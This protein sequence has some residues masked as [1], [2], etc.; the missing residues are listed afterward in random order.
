MEI[1]CR[2]LSAWG[3]GP[4]SDYK[5][6][7][8]I[9]IGVVFCP[10]DTNVV[11]AVF[12]KSSRRTEPLLPLLCLWP[13][14]AFAG[15]DDTWRWQPLESISIHSFFPGDYSLSRTKTIWWNELSSEGLHRDLF[16]QFIKR[17]PHHRGRH[18]LFRITLAETGSE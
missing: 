10:D 16:C 3:L 7:R 8:W 13:K 9:P 12:I 14:K 6:G 5:S 11:D 17:H 2:I 1:K 4:N 15:E 18:P